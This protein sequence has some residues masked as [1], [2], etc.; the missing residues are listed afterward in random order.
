MEEA[1]ALRTKRIMEASLKDL[2]EIKSVKG[3]MPK[4]AR[5]FDVLSSKY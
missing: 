4:K 5:I 3:P 2:F 1:K